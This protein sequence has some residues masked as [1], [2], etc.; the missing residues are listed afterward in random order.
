MKE[1]P[2]LKKATEAKNSA[3][4]LAMLIAEHNL[5]F[6]F[7]E[8][9]TK[10]LPALCPDSEI[11][12][13]VSCSRT[14]GRRLIVDVLGPERLEEAAFKL[15]TAK[16]SL[17]IDE[18]TD[19]S[20]N[21]CLVMVARYFDD[22]TNEIRDRC[23]GLLE[24]PCCTAAAL[25]S[26]IIEFL[27][28]HQI[29]LTNMIGFAADSAS[30][31]M[32]AL[33][34]IQAK[35]KEALPHLVVVGCLCHSFH[36]CAS[37][38]CLQLPRTVEDLARDIYSYFSHSPKRLA[39]FA[40]CQEIANLEPHRLLRP[41]QTRWL[42]LQA[43]VNRILEQ[44]P[45]LIKFFE[46]AAIEDSLQAA[47]TIMYT[48]KNPMFKL[49]FSFLSYVLGLINR[50]NLEF[51]SRDSLLYCLLD[52]VM[53]VYRTLL[54]NYL[55]TEYVMKTSTQSI[56]PGNVREYKPIEE[57]YL[58]ARV[59]AMLT[60]IQGYAD[61]IRDFKLRT[62]SFYVELCRQIK[63]RIKFNDPV[64]SALSILNPKVATSG[65]IASVIPLAL[66]FP[67]LVKEE[68][69]EELNSE[70]RL[71]PEVAE[72]SSTSVN[73]S[74]VQF[75][76][77]IGVIKNQAETL[78]FPRLHCFMKSLACLPHSSEAKARN[79]LK[80][81][82]SNTLILTKE[83]LHKKACYEWQ[84]NSKLFEQEKKTK[85]IDIESDSDDS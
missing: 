33:N 47:N 17:I 85:E 73:L 7:L 8:H 63:R 81:S 38:A 74:L 19:I 45:A 70:W 9:L 56:D 4:K 67:N 61:E 43:V 69:M 49:Y 16:F 14:K 84:P 46:I 28:L 51:Q 34:E 71:L 18:T 21:K 3:F 52:R 41:S 36:L 65:N 25:H 82:T 24:V 39:Q 72:L 59:E 44:W 57:L 48:L 11:A 29:P 50:L 32:G 15:R 30:V 62:L 53:E 40:G 80:V 22:D 68:N 60:G 66:L 27:T 26:A 1:N 5:P 78:M 6:K 37:A 54:K 23:V 79:K 42:S 83:L 12:K 13:K 35:L 20:T 75:I 55:K 10:L 2:R 58:G 77:K 64:L 76:N 31:M